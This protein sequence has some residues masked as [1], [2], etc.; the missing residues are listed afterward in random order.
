M[1]KASVISFAVLFVM[2][3]G[4]IGNGDWCDVEIYPE[5]P[6][7]C[8]VVVI[9]LSGFWGSSCIPNCSAISVEVNDIYFDV[10]WG[11]PPD[12][13]CLTVMT[14]WEL[15]ES[16][17]PLPCG[18]Y[19]IYARVVGY[20][21]APG[22]EPVAEFTVT[23]ESC[24]PTVYYVDAAN[25]NDLNDGLTF[26]TAFATIQ[27][28]IDA[29]LDGDTVIV[30]DGIYTGDGNR[31]ID[32]L[33]K[34]IT[35]HS[36]NGPNNC[37]IDCEN[38]GRGFYFHSGEDANSVVDGFTIENGFA[39]VGGGIYC[40]RS[41]PTITNC[42]VSGNSAVGTSWYPIAYG[43]GMYNS[44]SSPTI[45]NCT[46]SS[47]SASR[48]EAYGGGMYNGGS[49]P[50]ITNCTFSG[51]LASGSRVADGGGMSNWS[52]SLTVTNCA[53]SDNSAFSYNYAR[54]G[55]MRNKESS[56]T[57]TN[58]TFSGNSAAGGNFVRGGG[59]YNRSSNSVVTNCT[60]SGNPASR[61]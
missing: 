37:I 58:C 9:T 28:G 44:E 61:L 42:T 51:N 56:L 22:Y 39:D 11:Y 29:A 32:F 19:T 8:D 52:S 49:H 24:V 27:K 50:T 4:A 38:S 48:D 36:E 35:V 43:G 47:N 60:F 3:G 21:G 53:F 54:G 16:V 57:I 1:R 23:A 20:P 30:A 10:I 14:P 40:V 15:T 12:T 6:T 33:G 7:S 46:F 13:Y 41:S 31:D 25:G 34:A 59:M 26:E 55:G 17:G 5:H 18:T 45:A 2:A